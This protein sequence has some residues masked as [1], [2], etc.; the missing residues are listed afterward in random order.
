MDVMALPNLSHEIVLMSADSHDVGMV[1][2]GVE[3]DVAVAVVPAVG[4]G[5]IAE[6]AA[7][8]GALSYPT[9]LTRSAQNDVLPDHA[10]SGGDGRLS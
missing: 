1:P 2:A 3:V 9:D 4:S 6:T 7:I 5:L 8:D 10:L